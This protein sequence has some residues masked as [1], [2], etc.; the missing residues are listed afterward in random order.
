MPAYVAIAWLMDSVGRRGPVAA[1]LVL[2]GAC[3]A[4]PTDS[5]G[6]PL[7]SK[8]ASGAA[9]AA[10]FVQGAELFPTSVRSSAM[11]LMSASARVGA[12]VAPFVPIVFDA[13]SAHVLLTPMGVYGVASMLAGV[14]CWQLLPETLNAPLR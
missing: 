4:G 7:L 3:I 8:S 2:G 1:F 6:L 13:H 14:L 5:V 11:G 10:A 9:L 12:M